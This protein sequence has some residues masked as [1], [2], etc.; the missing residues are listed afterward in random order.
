MKHLPLVLATTAIVATQIACAYLLVSREP[1]SGIAAQQTIALM[2]VQ[3]LA[4]NRASDL[5]YDVLTPSQRDAVL[6]AAVA[7]RAASQ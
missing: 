7:L 1:P 6:Q 3:A 4:A 5:C 2:E